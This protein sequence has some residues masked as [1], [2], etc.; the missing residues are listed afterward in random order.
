MSVKHKFAMTLT[1]FVSLILLQTVWL[2]ALAVDDSVPHPIDERGLLSEVA[3]VTTRLFR[4]VEI[5]EIRNAALQRPDIT[6][7]PGT[8]V[9]IENRDKANH[10]LIFMQAPGND[11]VG[12]FKS[13]AIGPED[14]WGA[15]F[16]NVGVYPYECS[17]HPEE[18]HGV[19]RVVHP[20][21]E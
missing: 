4:T 2:D 5:I 20:E 12:S 17:V 16:L 11:I 8:V 1:L 21:N 3:I 19:V 15:E 7:A 13:G 10:R 9:V 18:E 14:R 6:I